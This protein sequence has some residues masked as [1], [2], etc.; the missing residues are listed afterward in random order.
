M[1]LGIERLPLGAHRDVLVL[2]PGLGERLV[3]VREDVARLAAGVDVERLFE[4][5]QVVNC[6]QARRMAVGESLLTAKRTFADSSLN[7]FI[8]VAAPVAGCDAECLR[9]SKQEPTRSGLALLS[10]SRHRKNA[11]SRPC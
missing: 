4:V 5:G 11:A 2:R 10:F 3:V 8:R 7:R 9:T 6:A 1:R